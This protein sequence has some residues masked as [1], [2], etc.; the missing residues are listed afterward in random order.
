MYDSL[1]EAQEIF[2]EFEREKE[3]DK[4]VDQD[5]IKKSSMNQNEME[6][7]I[8]DFSFDNDLL[9]DFHYDEF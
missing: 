8:Y 7:Q 3:K 2:K 1:R 4:Q 6:A 5:I 9:N